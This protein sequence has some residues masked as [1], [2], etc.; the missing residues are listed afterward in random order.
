MRTIS[1]LQ[2]ELDATADPA[3]QRAL[4]QRIAEKRQ[5]LALR[6]EKLRRAGS[7]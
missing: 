6:L 3:A 7:L 2:R 5:H 1:A 4:Q